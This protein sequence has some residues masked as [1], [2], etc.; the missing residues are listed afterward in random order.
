ML[1]FSTPAHPANDHEAVEDVLLVRRDWLDL[2]T[3]DRARV[4]NLWAASE[5]VVQ[6][7]AYYGDEAVITFKLSDGE[8]QL[9]D[10]HTHVRSGREHVALGA[11]E[12]LAAHLDVLIDTI[13][14]K[15]NLQPGVP[16]EQQ[17]ADN[18]AYAAAMFG[19][20][21]PALEDMEGE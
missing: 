19:A 11:L 20:S 6:R 13:D 4:R 2:P 12:E 1:P 5:V 9:F 3:Q 7:H 10:I 17:E 8:D 21:M 14:E 16:L 15:L 18:A